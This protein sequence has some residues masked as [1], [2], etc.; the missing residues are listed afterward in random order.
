MPQHYHFLALAFVLFLM[1]LAIKTK[2]TPKDYTIADYSKSDIHNYAKQKSILTG[3][4]LILYRVIRKHMHDDFIVSPK[5]RLADFV[6]VK[7]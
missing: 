1:L 2:L 6:K 7:K 4:E 5:V 3:P